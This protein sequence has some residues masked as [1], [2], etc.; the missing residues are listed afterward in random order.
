MNEDIITKYRPTEYDTVLGQEGVVRALTATVQ[1]GTAHAFLF[2][3]PS[4][5]GKTTLARITAKAFHCEEILQEDAATNT[6]IDNIRAIIDGFLFRPLAGASKG[7]II[8]EVHA[9]SKAA[10]TALLLTLE[11]PPP[12]IYWFLCTTEPSKLP[13]AVR[14][15]CLHYT[16]REVST[17][18]IRDF[19]EETDEGADAD[20]G[21]LDLCAREAFGSVR[22]ALANLGVCFAAK[23]RKEAAELLRTAGDV[24]QA[25]ELARCLIAGDGWTK[26][27]SLLT[28]M[29]DTNPESI[30][31]VVRAY[32][33]KVALN[34][35][36][37]KDVQQALAVLEAF[38]K[39]FHTADGMSPVVLACGE[40]VYART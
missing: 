39:P 1:K 30:R 9:L 34:G 22:Q 13:E 38:S 24:P 10:V 12:Y 17:D 15:R 6:G 21:V 11:E 20:P 26:I 5:V 2:S 8:D 23:D 3:G 40:L 35:K 36:N 14:T 25:F 28:A 7:I 33:T 27:S 16:L 37:S 31:H 4:G 18:V 19:L 32:M 29:K